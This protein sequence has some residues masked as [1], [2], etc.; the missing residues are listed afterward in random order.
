MLISKDMN[1]AMNEQIGNELAASNQY[2]SIAVYF[3]GEGLPGL[4]KH[5]YKQ[6]AEERTHAMR[7][8]KYLIDADGAVEIPAI[9]APASRFSSAE[10][11]VKLS[12]D[13]EM[14]VTMQ[15]NGLMDLAIK[16]GDHLSKNALEWFVGEQREEVSSMDT[17]LRM[18]RRAGEPGLFFVENYILQGGLSGKEGADDEGEAE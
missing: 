18:V 13:S 11:A 1:A 4:A 6:A 12:Y 3:D 17:L 2:V 5:F 14:R 10:E 8:V 16:E 7:F 9:P 15:I